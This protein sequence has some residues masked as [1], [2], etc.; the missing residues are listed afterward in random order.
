M[1]TEEI[2]L[3]VSRETATRFRQEPKKVR[4][5]ITRFID[6]WFHEPDEQERE[7]AKQRLIKTMD[8]MSK[9]AEQRGLTTEKFEELLGIPLK[10][11]L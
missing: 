2:T 4:E 5:G 10:H 9:E 1:E 3:K 8:A 6:A 7:Q 11:L